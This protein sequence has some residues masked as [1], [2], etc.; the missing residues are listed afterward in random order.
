MGTPRPLVSKLRLV[1]LR[2]LI[3]AVIPGIDQ[4]CVYA[5]VMAL[6]QDALN[7]DIVDI[8]SPSDCTRLS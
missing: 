1:S 8:I 6:A 2:G 3:L 7:C 5:S 4:N